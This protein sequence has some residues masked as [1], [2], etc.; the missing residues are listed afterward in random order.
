MKPWEL[1]D[2][3]VFQEPSR[4]K[5]KEHRQ[6]EF[7]HKQKTFLR[8]VGGNLA[9]YACVLI[10]VM[11]IVFIWVDIGFK[12]DPTKFI[13]E[14]IVSVILFIAGEYLTSKMGAPGGRLDEHYVKAHNEYLETRKTVLQQG[15]S[16]MNEFCDAQ[17]EE[18]Y[19]RYIRRKCRE[20]RLNYD[21]YVKKYSKMR[22]KELKK[23]FKRKFAL[24]VFA[25]NKARRIELTPNML[26][27]DGKVR[28][29]RGGIPISGEEYVEQH[30]T[31]FWHVALSIVVAILTVLPAF[32]PTEDVTIGR[33]MFT[34]F[35]LAMLFYRMYSGYARS[36]KA[37]N[38]IEP[39]HLCVKTTYLNLYLEFLK[40]TGEDYGTEG[41]KSE[42][43]DPQGRREGEGGGVLHDRPAESV[44]ASASG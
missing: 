31:G 8:L 38:T 24:A 27:T 10:V 34:I 29:E 15:V 7:N 41:S 35:K 3:S 21:E 23:I 28:G 16:R 19:D 18:E 39:R 32:T 2:D 13:V 43:T 33:V 9:A 22:Y 12:I 6:K 5:I 37:Y 1:G 11:L 17:I 44:R 26:M 14:S 42:Q 40:R 30:T 4:E 25:L 36:A 20:Y